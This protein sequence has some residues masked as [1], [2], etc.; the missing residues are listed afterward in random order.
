M[1]NESC[2]L[3]RC[4]RAY[5]IAIKIA[6]SS[7]SKLVPFDEMALANLNGIYLCPWTLISTPA[8]VGPG[9]YRADPSVYANMVLSLISLL[10][11]S[12]YCLKIGF[13]A[14]TLAKDC[15]G[16]MVS[17]FGIEKISREDGI[18]FGYLI[19]SDPCKFIDCAELT[20]SCL[21]RLEIQ[22]KCVL[23]D[24]WFDLFILFEI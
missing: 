1:L 10:I 14:L 16:R 7:P 20:K 21:A 18:S 6:A 24:V 5:C 11:K 3:V 9:F 4:V 13:W 22:A 17:M 19:F 23:K 8:P 15:S 2:S 12:K